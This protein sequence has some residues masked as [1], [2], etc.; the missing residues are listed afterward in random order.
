MVL[1]ER[2]WY[3]LQEQLASAVCQQPL[4]LTI[5]WESHQS[6]FWAQRPL[7]SLSVKSVHLVTPCSQRRAAIADRRPFRR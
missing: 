5:A 7:I 1:P 2:W 3:W 6:P 4:V